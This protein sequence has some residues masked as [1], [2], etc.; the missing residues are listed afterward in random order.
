MMVRLEAASNIL[1]FNRFFTFQF[2][3]GAIGRIALQK[4]NN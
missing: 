2:H 3:D 4:N 1:A